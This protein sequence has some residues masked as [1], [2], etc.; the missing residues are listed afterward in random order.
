MGRIHQTA[1]EQ[2]VTLACMDPWGRSVDVSTTLG[3]R[4][5][6][7]YAITLTVHSSS[8][9]VVWMMARLVLLQG[10]TA[11]AGE[12]DIQVYP[13][14]D[15]TGRAVTVLDFCSPYGRLVGQVSTR[16]LQDFVA[17]SIAVVPVGDESEH[18]DIDALADALLSSVA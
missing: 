16:E 6:D 5:E 10:L 18:L 2:D 14:I 12:G 13:S 11:P 7:P 1:V 17:S 4:Q 15:D 8:G 3:Y 9:D